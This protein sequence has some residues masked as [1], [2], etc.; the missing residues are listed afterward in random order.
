VPV[1]DSLLIYSDIRMLPMITLCLIIN[2][3]DRS[4]VTSK[5]IHPKYT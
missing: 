3:L 4:N 5:P 1:T 2:Y